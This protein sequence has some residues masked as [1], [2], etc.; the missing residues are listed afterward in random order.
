MSIDTAIMT[1]PK[2]CRYASGP[3]DQDFSGISPSSAFF[4]YP[5]QP[6]NLARS[7]LDCTTILRQYSTKETWVS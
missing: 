1:P 4:I 7:I 5:S 2:Y 6:V 3:C